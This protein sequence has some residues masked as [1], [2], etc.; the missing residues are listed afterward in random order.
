VSTDLVLFLLRV[1]SGLALIALLVALFIILWREYRATAYDVEARRRTYGRLIAIHE[2]DGQYMISGETY[3][4]LPITTIGRSPTNSITIDDTFASS[5]HAIVTMRDGQWW[6][7][8]RR[9]RNGTLLNDIPVTEPM[10][11]THGDII[12]VGSVH[13]RLELE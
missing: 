9:S 2:I 7:E 3:P 6:L 13:L 12:G 1:V 5:E 11:I 8:D 4:L 10:V